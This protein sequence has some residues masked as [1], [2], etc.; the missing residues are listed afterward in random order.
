ME[1]TATCTHTS[2][3]LYPPAHK[4]GLTLTLGP[5]RGQRPCQCRRDRGLCF[6]LMNL[7]VALMQGHASL[8]HVVL[9][10]ACVLLKRA[11]LWLS[12]RGSVTW[13]LGR[14]FVAEHTPV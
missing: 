3:S 14:R 11:L 4:H 7:L 1:S 6:V 10:S 12:F 5:Q 8:P 9:I 2:L 13:G